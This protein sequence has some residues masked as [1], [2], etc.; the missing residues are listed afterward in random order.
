MRLLLFTSSVLV[1]FAIP[2]VASSPA[3]EGLSKAR[4]QYSVV[5][6]RVTFS[7]IVQ[8]DG[9]KLPDSIVLNQLSR[10]EKRVV[11]SLQVGSN[12]RPFDVRIVQSAYPA[13]DQPVLRAVRDF[14]FTPAWVGNH[15][16]PSP[17]TMIVRLHG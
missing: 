7:H 5:P 8:T 17:L 9:V 11:V 2:A 13:L 14:R 1:F 6:P 12:G 10:A 4:S 15:P 3:S 16:V